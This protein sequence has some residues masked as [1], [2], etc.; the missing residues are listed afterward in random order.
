[1][2]KLRFH[3]TLTK[4]KWQKFSSAQQI[5]MIANELNRAI[6]WIK[7]GDLEEVNNCYKRAF[8]L[9]DLTVSI[10]ENY[11]KQKE[12]LRLRGLI[13]HQYILPDKDLEITKKL[14]SVLILIDP[15]SYNLL[16]KSSK[17]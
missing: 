7:K 1:M 8:E 16:S 2:Y 15:G 6:N 12:L 5:I 3:K 11:S 4:E 9:L 17:T 10:S 13:S 14:L